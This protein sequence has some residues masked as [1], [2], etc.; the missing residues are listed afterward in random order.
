MGQD[1]ADTMTDNEARFDRYFGTLRSCD[2]LFGARILRLDDPAKK[3]PSNLC[4]ALRLIRNEIN[5]RFATN[6]ADIVCPSGEVRLHTDY[7]ASSEINAFAFQFEGW[8]F[9]G[10]TEGMLVHFAR[11]CHDLWRLS[12]VAELLEVDH[13]EEKGQ[14]ILQSLL[15]IE[16]QYI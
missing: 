9:I 13:T 8:Y 2:S 4:Q 1:R 14:V 7:I 5:G 10:I 6:A 12:S 16:L 15:L 3:D 11:T